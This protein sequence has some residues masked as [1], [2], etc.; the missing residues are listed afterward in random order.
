MKH[1]VLA[2]VSVSG[3]CA[4]M[5]SGAVAMAADPQPAEITPFQAAPQAQEASK[6]AV[7]ANLSSGVDEV[8]KMTRAQISEDVIATYIQASGSVY[9]LKP[10][11]IVTLHQQG[12][13]DRIVTLMLA[14]GHLD[15]PSTNQP[16][17]VMPPPIDPML[18]PVP[19]APAQDQNQ[20][21]IPGQNAFEI[22]AEGPP[23]TYEPVST[24]YVIPDNTRSGIGY[25][26]VYTYYSSYGSF[27]CAAPVIYFG[28][29]GYHRHH[30][31]HRR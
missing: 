12:V 27:G 31:F 15:A 16:V 29:G 24:V 14:Q 1:S 13:S 2:I 30:S 28:G 18:A 9:N 5:L 6:P 17:M 25:R 7:P 4:A 8:V 11:D 3:V 10:A 22:A 20:M 21:F 26:P 23:A 19:I